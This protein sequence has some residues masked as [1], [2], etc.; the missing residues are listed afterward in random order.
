[1]LTNPFNAK[2]IKEKK[3]KEDK[4]KEKAAPKWNPHMPVYASCASGSAADMANQRGKLASRT[5]VPA[6]AQVPPSAV[7]PAA[8]QV[9]PSA[10]ESAPTRC[11][12][13]W[14]PSASPH[15]V[16]RD[17]L[18]VVSVLRSEG[19]QTDEEGTFR[20]CVMIICM[21]LTPSTYPSSLL[22]RLPRRSRFNSRSSAARDLPVLAQ[23]RCVPTQG[24][25]PPERARRRKTLEVNSLSQ[26]F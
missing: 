8:A 16:P 7:D 20:P 15:P 6:A 5:V 1:M 22:G 24:P 10:A 13:P 4:A 14:T 3:R 2:S 21:Y 11:R 12:S 25:R 18:R 9:P 17:H 23:P 19:R 26:F